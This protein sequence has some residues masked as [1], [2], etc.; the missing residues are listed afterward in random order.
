ME[1]AVFLLTAA[2]TLRLLFGSPSTSGLRGSNAQMV[3]PAALFLVLLSLQL[4]PLPPRLVHFISPPTF[5]LYQQSLPGWPNRPVYN[6]P[7]PL[8]ATAASTPVVLSS[9]AEV[10]AGA[11]IPFTE[12]RAQNSI[13]TDAG[14]NPERR[15]VALWRTLSIDDAL[16]W[17][18]LLKLLSYACLFLLVVAY[19]SSKISWPGFS[20]GLLRTALLAGVLVASAALVERVFSNGRAL[21]LFSPYDWGKGNPWGSRATGPFANPDHLADYLNLILPIALAGF[22]RPAA[23]AVRRTTLMRPF[24]GA[25]VL[26]MSCAL[27]LTS[28]RGGWIGAVVSFSVLAALWPWGRQRSHA[29]LATG[30]ATSIGFGL[31]VLLLLGPVGRTQA[32]VRLGETVNQDSLLE[33]MRPAQASLQIV[34]DFPLFGVGLGC[35]PEIFPR[36]RPAPWSPIFWNAAHNDYVQLAAETGLPGVGLLIWFFWLAVRRV[37]ARV[38]LMRAEVAPL[39]AVCVAGICGAA[40]HEFFDFPLQIPA[41]A[42]LFT[43]LLGTAVR[44]ARREGP[45]LARERTGAGLIQLLALISLITL[46]GFALTQNRIPYPYSL[47]P[48]TTPAQATSLVNVHPANARVHLLLVSAI[49][50]R[51]PVQ[52][53]IAEL[54]TALWLEPT[55]P[56][57][58]DLYAKSL[59]QAH[60]LQQGLDEIS[61]SI[62][63][64]PTIDTHFYLQPRIVPWLTP[65]ERRAVEK[66]FGIAVARRYEGAIENFANYDDSIGDFAAEAALYREAAIKAQDPQRRAVYLVDAGISY[67]KAGELGKAEAVLVAAAAANPEDPASYEQLAVRVYGPKKNLVAAKSAV[68]R[69]IEGGA[70]P[71]RLWLALASAAQ[72]AGNIR[73]AEAALEKAVA[74]RPSSFEALMELG[75]LDLAINR[76]EQAAVW[77]QRATKVQS[78]SAE[79]F[80]DLALADEAAYEYFAADQAYQQA[81]SLAPSDAHLR[82][83]YAAFRQKLAQSQEGKPKP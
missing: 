27:V 69:G 76:F 13:S 78:T 81:I 74:L 71:S 29:L 46:T 55:N 8:A 1:A 22:I 39:L 24:C 42:L 35:W 20:P 38:K 44:L 4:T 72:M 52:R 14:K 5:E 3:M 34:R 77:F 62:S 75:R 25:V 59:L 17:P 15:V 56:L 51:A 37:P 2:W 28:S 82:E 50:E 65:P 6:T 58:R 54:R 79:A 26:L 41:C 40:V 12:T 21:W 19:P 30:I 70:D 80:F 48:P 73:E 32:D 10:T 66:G 49:G 43:V 63:Y 23:L 36:Y 83:R 31:L 67:A 60:A 53:R 33:R 45:R 11:A 47:R 57:A 18:A 64:S 7:I 16:T 61:R 9:S 68:A